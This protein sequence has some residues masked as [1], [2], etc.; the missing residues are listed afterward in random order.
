MQSYVF[1]DNQKNCQKSRVNYVK[2]VVVVAL[3]M[4]DILLFS[5]FQFF[6]NITYIN[7]KQL[8][9]QHIHPPILHRFL[10]KTQG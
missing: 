1:V 7:E 6:C 4:V 10:L 5:T 3:G 2:L 9:Q 8:Q